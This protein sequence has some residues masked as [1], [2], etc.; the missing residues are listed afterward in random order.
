[1]FEKEE[2][3]FF[4]GNHCDH[5]VEVIRGSKKAEK[6]ICCGEELSKLL[7]KDSE[8][9]AEKHLPVIRQ[10]KNKVTVAVGSIYHPMEEK[11][12]IGFVYLKTKNGCQRVDLSHTDKPVVE[13]LLPDGDKPLAAYAFCNLHG[14][15]KTDIK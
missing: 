1:M 3:V 5:I 15:W 7:V 12:S 6:I 11:H 10:E 13:F 8:E 9:I 14:F 4:A 2:A